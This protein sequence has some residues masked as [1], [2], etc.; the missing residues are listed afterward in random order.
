VDVSISE[1]LEAAGQSLAAS[2]NAARAAR[3]DAKAIALKAIELG[4]SEYAVSQALRV[5]R[6]TLRKWLGKR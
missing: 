3:D 2:R 4:W 1:M 6:M 5:D